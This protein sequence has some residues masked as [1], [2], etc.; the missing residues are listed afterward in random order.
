[1]IRAK[2]GSKGLGHFSSHLGPGGAPAQGVHVQGWGWNFP[3]ERGRGHSH[4]I[5]RGG[6]GLVAE[7]DQEQRGSGSGHGS[8][9]SGRSPVCWGA[10][11]CRWDLAVWDAP[12]PHALR[13]RACHGC[14]C[15]LPAKE[16]QSS[17]ST[18]FGGGQHVS[19]VPSTLTTPGHGGKQCRFCLREPLATCTALDSTRCSVSFVRVV[20]LCPWPGGGYSSEEQ[21]VGSL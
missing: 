4:D 14:A 6:Q 7:P 18:I 12:T 19:L 21:L 20:F 9:G 17:S 10:R 1:M 13:A 5:P 8:H 3:A 2:P 11:A 15:C 16:V